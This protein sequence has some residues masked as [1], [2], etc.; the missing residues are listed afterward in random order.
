MLGVGASLTGIG[1][2]VKDVHSGFKAQ[3]S[4]SKWHRCWKN[5]YVWRNYCSLQCFSSCFPGHFRKSLRFESHSMVIFKGF[6]PL[7][8]K[9]PLLCS[10]EGGTVIRPQ[11]FP[12]TFIRAVTKGET[13][14]ACFVSSL[15]K[16]YHFWINVSPFIAVWQMKK[17]YVGHT[18][19]T[20]GLAR[21]VDMNPSRLVWIIH[22]HFLKSTFL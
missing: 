12:I 1:N 9:R 15:I 14:L 5:S 4:T 3:S 21:R 7:K 11:D 22:V 19:R 16:K 18:G 8:F 20:G 6:C 10:H 2:F 13:S 17:S